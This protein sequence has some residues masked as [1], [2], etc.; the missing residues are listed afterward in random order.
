MSDTPLAIG[1]PGSPPTVA[2][3]TQSMFQ[4]AQVSTRMIIDCAWAQRRPN[5]VAYTDGCTW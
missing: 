3:P 4:T 5:A 2:A 1:T